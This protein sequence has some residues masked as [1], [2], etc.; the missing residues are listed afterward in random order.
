MMMALE[1]LLPTLE[2]LIFITS[3]TLFL[4][5]ALFP[6]KL[7][8]GTRAEKISTWPSLTVMLLG[9]LSVF[10]ITICSL[11]LM[12]MMDLRTRLEILARSFVI[13]LQTPYFQGALWQPL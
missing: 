10:R 11:A 13:A 1:I 5:A 9:R 3:L 4:V 2:Q 12:V 8:M 6:H 7:A